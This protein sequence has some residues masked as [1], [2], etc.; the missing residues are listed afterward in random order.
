MECPDHWQVIKVF[1]WPLADNQTLTEY[2]CV[3]NNRVDTR[4]TVWCGRTQCSTCGLTKEHAFST[5]FK[6]G[7]HCAKP[8][9]FVVVSHT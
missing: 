6:S 9:D 5:D 1:D 7:P 4:H 3:P 8:C 2:R